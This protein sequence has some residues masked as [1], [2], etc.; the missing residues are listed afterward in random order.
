MDDGN[1]NHAMIRRALDEKNKGFLQYGTPLNIIFKG[2]KKIHIHNP[3]IGGL[4]SQVEANKLKDDI[5][6][7]K[8][9]DLKNRDFASRLIGLR[10][11][12][13]KKINNNIDDDDYSG[14]FGNMD[15]R[16]GKPSFFPPQRTAAP[17]KEK[18]VNDLPPSPSRTSKQK[19]D[20][21]IRRFHEFK[22]L[23]FSDK[24]S[25]LPSPLTEPVIDSI[26]HNTYFTPHY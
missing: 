11:P 9:D 1:F 24:P 7:Q 21:L 22:K 18:C 20:H 19:T 26:F 3:I 14:G 10:L 16:S 12:N 8:L 25:K 5:L 23:I 2:A 13:G 15:F 6:K 17:V 4:L